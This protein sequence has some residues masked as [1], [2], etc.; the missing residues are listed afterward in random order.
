[1]MF[2]AA[3]VFPYLDRVPGGFL[4]GYRRRRRRCVAVVRLRFRSVLG[5]EVKKVASR[6]RH[7]S[8]LSD[9]QSVVMVM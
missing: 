2:H 4:N 9:S 7:R 6:V 1:M 5:R 8:I 3:V